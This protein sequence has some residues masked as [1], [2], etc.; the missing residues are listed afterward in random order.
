MKS[1]NRIL[2]A[3][4]AAAT[5]SFASS[6]MAQLPMED[7]ATVASP[8]VRQALNDKKAPG[9]IAVAETKH[10]K[11]ACCGAITAAKTCCETS[12]VASPKVRQAVG[13]AR[14]CAS[15]GDSVASTTKPVDDGIV[16]SPKVRQQLNEHRAHFEIAP[17]K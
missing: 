13:Q 4:A 10:V 14:C 11:K 1:L 15:S 3:A 6:T 17:V 2:F 8:K 5:L 12:R 7:G 9:P 16:A